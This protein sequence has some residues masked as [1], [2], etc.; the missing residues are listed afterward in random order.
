[1]TRYNYPNDYL[2]DKRVPVTDSVGNYLNWNVGLDGVTIGSNVD[3]NYKL[4][5]YDSSTFPVLKSN[6]N[7]IVG[8]EM[9]EIKNNKQNKRT[10]YDNETN[11]DKNTVTIESSNSTR[12]MMIINHNDG[13]NTVYSPSRIA[14]NNEVIMFKQDDYRNKN[15]FVDYVNI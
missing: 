1:M 14:K 12:G 8:L 5:S 9:K 15:Y 2:K 3:I 10:E 11:V 7:I 6:K 13:T 4:T